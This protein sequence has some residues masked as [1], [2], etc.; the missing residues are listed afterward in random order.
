M[1]LLQKQYQVEPER[2]SSGIHKWLI[3]ITLFI[4]G[5]TI[6]GDLI[7]VLYKFIDGQD[8]TTGFLL[9]VLVLLVMAGGVFAYYISDATGK[10]TAQSRMMWRVGS[11]VLV[12]GSIVWGFAVLG[13][14]ASQ[15]L[16][17]YD[18]QKLSDLQTINQSVISYY[19]TN[20]GLPGSLSDLTKS[21]NYYIPAD[22]QSG[23]FY[24]YVLVGQSAKAYQLCAEFNN[25]SNGSNGNGRS[26]PVV[27]PSGSIS[28]NHPAGHY[29][30]TETIPTS[31]YPGKLPM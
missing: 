28:W 6:A 2:Q 22:P 10:L 8:L 26:V 3:Y 21:G 19:Q 7:S 5:L 12:V 4:S 25:A 24:E 31:M 17:K 27:Y 9:K 15:R 18:E 20:S 23:K 29:C 1:W 14:P 16:N 11:G 13:T 30:F